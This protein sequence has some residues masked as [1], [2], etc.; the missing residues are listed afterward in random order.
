MLSLYHLEKI[1]TPARLL[2][3]RSIIRAS[4]ARAFKPSEFSC[5]SANNLPIQLTSF[6]GRER[7][8]VAL[9]RL[10]PTTRLLTLTGAGGVGKTRLSLAVAASE[11]DQFPDGAWWVELAPLADPA[12]VPQAVASAL[13]MREEPGRPI[14]ATLIDYLRDKCLLLV[15]DNCEHLITACAALADALLHAAPRVRILASSREALGIAGETEYHVPSMLAPNPREP[16]TATDIGKYEA[17]QLFVARAAATKSNFALSSANAPAVAQVCYQLDGIPLAIELAAARI[18][19]FSAEQIAGRLDDRF[20]LLTGGSRTALP[21]QQTLRGAIDWSYSLLPELERVLLCRLSVFAGGWSFEAAEAVCTAA[22][23]EVADI[24]DLLTHLVEKSLVVAD[25][26]AGEVRY[27][28]LETIRQYAHEKLLEAGEGERLADQ[29]LAFFRRLA[30]RAEAPLQSGSYREWMPR[31]E[32]EHD[33]LRAALDWGCTHDLE[34]ARLLAGQLCTFWYFA[35]HFNEA[36]TWYERVLRLGDG[37]AETKGMALALDAAGWI[38]GYLL[39]LDD[40]ERLLE[41]SVALW[42]VLDDQARLA[43]ALGHL[44]FVKIQQGDSEGACILYEANELIIRQFA[45]P[46]YLA[47]ALTFWGQAVATARADYAAARLLHEESLALGL[48]LKSSFPLVNAYRNLAKLA[49]Q[50]GDYALARQHML[51]AV[52]W[53]RQEGSRGRHAVALGQLA[54]VAS[55]QGDYAEAR[56]LYDEAV[57]TLRALGDQAHA[58]HI[59][60]GLGY[61]AVQRGEF[62]Q[63][64]VIFAESLAIFGKVQFELGLARCLAG[65]A[66]LRLAQGRVEQAVRLLASEVVYAHSR[67]SH[68]PIDRIRYERTLAAARAQ[69]GEAAFNAAWDAGRRL[70]R[71]EDIAL[72]Q[73]APPISPPPKPAAPAAA[74]KPP[75]GE[76]SA[77]ER[78]VALLV[79]QGQSNRAIAEHLVLSERTVEGHV[80]NVLAKLGF[81]ARAQ[82]AAWVVQSGL[83]KGVST[84]RGPRA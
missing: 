49:T 35:D 14:L 77:R 84:P 29:H 53:S 30:E 59:A 73:S 25:E 75:F 65:Y 46:E 20:R 19:V 7:E 79:A 31:L 17:V 21:R 36:R 83:D 16:I 52:T 51:E 57:A 78:E 2:R 28:M 74:A 62:E 56:V 55:L 64:A 80:R 38:D 33:N 8:L 63:A 42:R 39:A 61:L 71:A 48:K 76:L 15:L 72:A 47:W 70:T 10:L 26:E 45:S 1:D 3:S 67:T 66:D 6:V 60:I 24:L 4:A 54:D 82:I 44:C 50:Q 41:H 37:A 27:H 68:I 18:K 40:A 5:M 13:G 11:L 23:I 12:L 22:G 32:V 43:Q 34:A 9:Q 58:A 81:N 69:L